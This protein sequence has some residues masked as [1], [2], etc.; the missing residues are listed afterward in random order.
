MFWW[1]LRKI[2]SSQLSVLIDLPCGIH[3]ALKKFV[4]VQFLSNWILGDVFLGQ[5][6]VHSS[7]H[8]Y[9]R[10]FPWVSAFIGY[11][12]SAAPEALRTWLCGQMSPSIYS[13]LGVTIV[14]VLP[15]YGFLDWCQSCNPFPWLAP[16][17]DFSLTIFGFSYLT[18]LAIF[19][20]TRAHVI[21]FQWLPVF[22]IIL[23]GYDD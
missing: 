14:K 19:A 23:H 15:R 10:F 1:T 3:H 6:F 8:F 5:C 2:F 20:H 7:R 13:K 11:S 17:P 18:A 4:C 16:V 9:V 12:W 22:N 21:S